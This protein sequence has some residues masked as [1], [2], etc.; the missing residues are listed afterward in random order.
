MPCYRCGARQVDPERGPSPWRRGV[1]DGELVLVCPQCQAGRDWTA[2]LDRCGACGSTALAKR[3]GEVVCRACGAMVAMSS[4]GA[5]A[6]AE[7]GRDLGDE[8]SRALD[9]LFGR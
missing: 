1:R 6:E 3:L 4:G 7:R 2:D 8:V 9:R 5:A